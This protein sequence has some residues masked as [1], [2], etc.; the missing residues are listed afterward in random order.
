[1]L[2]VLGYL[3]YAIARGPLAPA[4]PWRSKSFEW[5][6][7]SPPPPE[8]FETVPEWTDGPYSYEER[9]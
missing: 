3:I 7:S 9:P 4:N 6:T 5:R 8:N 1:M 2:T